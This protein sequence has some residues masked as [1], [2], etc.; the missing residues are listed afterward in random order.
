MHPNHHD[1]SSPETMRI[2]GAGYRRDKGQRRLPQD[3]IDWTSIELSIE[4]MAEP[5]AHDPFDEDAEDGQGKS[6]PRQENLAQIGCIW[7]TKAPS[8]EEGLDGSDAAAFERHVPWA[9]GSCDGAERRDTR[10]NDS[11]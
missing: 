6:H 2:D 7:K 1:K 3:G 10:L 9:F 11:L 5:D 8:K 4:L